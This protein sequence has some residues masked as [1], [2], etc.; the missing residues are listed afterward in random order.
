MG[1]TI[2]LRRLHK[3]YGTKPQ[4]NLVG[5]WIYY[6][7]KVISHKMIEREM[8]NRGSKSVVFNTVKEQR[9]DGSYI[10]K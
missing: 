2:K 7:C 6:S 1:E 4:G 8:G 5:G 9:V 3:A 10:E